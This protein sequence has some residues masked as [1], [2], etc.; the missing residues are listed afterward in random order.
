M[1]HDACRVM[2]RSQPTLSI[3]ANI[4]CMINDPLLGWWVTCPCE[5][6][7]AALSSPPSAV[8]ALAKPRGPSDQD[9]EL[10]STQS[11][12]ATKRGS[13]E[14]QQITA[15]AGYDAAQA[16]APHSADASSAR[17]S[18]QLQRWAAQTLD[19]VSVSMACLWQQSHGRP[20]EPCS[21]SNFELSSVLV[22]GCNGAGSS[23]ACQEQT[24]APYT[25]TNSA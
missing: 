17:K 23:R 9:M 18:P 3:I 16:R 7:V 14:V 1:C 11:A 20:S 4:R 12:P 8:P 5:A 22:S 10:L 25:R 13:K 6:G 2:T 24:S 21:V 15:A 19:L